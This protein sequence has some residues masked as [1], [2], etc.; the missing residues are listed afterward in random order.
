L[1]QKYAANGLVLVAPTPEAE[2]SAKKFKEKNKVDYPLLTGAQKAC[3]AYKVR[4][5]PMM[6]LVGKDG[7]VA[8]EGHFEDAALH[9]AIETT[10]GIK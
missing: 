2:E 10:L 1:A 8:W 4:G 3:E 6:F 9:K 5:Y 7:K